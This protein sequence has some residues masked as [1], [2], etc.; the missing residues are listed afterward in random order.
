MTPEQLTAV[1]TNERRVYLSA[2]AGSG[3]TT[4]STARTERLLKED[5]DPESMLS[6]SF[7][8]KA[9][10]ELRE[11]LILALGNDEAARETVAK[12]T[13]GT[14][15]S[16]CYRILRAYGSRIGYV[17]ADR[18]TIVDAD[19][20]DLLL[21]RICQDFGYL[22]V[23]GNRSKWRSGLSLKRVKAWRDAAYT[24]MECEATAAHRPILDRILNRYWSELKAGYVLDFGKL[25][26]E[27]TRLF[28]E[29]PDVMELY[30]ARYKWIFVD[31]AQ[32]LSR[33]LH[34]FL[35]LLMADANVF[36]IAD[37]R[38][39]IYRFNGA[40]P[41][42]LADLVANHGFTA[43]SIPHTF[44]CPVSI[45]E[46]SNKL[47]WVNNEPNSPPAI[48][49]T[50]RQGT[51]ELIPGRTAA[52]IDAVRRLRTEH[53]YGWAEIAILARKHSTL[54]HIRFEMMN[55]RIPC[56]QS[57]G[58][59]EMSGRF[60]KL[61][62][63]LIRLAVNPADRFAF[64]RLANEYGLS[65]EE[66]GAIRAAAAS[67]GTA[68]MT[69]Y[70][71]GDYGSGIYSD[72]WNTEEPHWN[73]LT[74]KGWGTDCLADFNAM[75]FI[76]LAAE[77]LRI[78]YSVEGVAPAAWWRRH[79][80][81]GEFESL[82][83]ALE[84]AATFDQDKGDDWKVGDSVSLS[85]I[86][87]AKGLEYPAVILVEWNDG[88]FP[89]RRDMATEADLQ[90]SRRLAYVGMTRAKSYLGI[91]FRGPNDFGESREITPPSRFIAEAGL[92]T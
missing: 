42:L 37:Q 21:E 89:S 72:L 60:W 44:R 55:A 50:K 39:S 32:D 78:R 56:H 85:T 74:A 13:M 19:E 83:E 82:S 1:N 7:T 23:E 70:V 29:H 71:W 22:T 31:E 64:L 47:I 53:A 15:H 59:N 2:S 75:P 84:F 77:C 36:L 69:E 86:H 81:A 43:L 14:A 90:E 10:S 35:F 45:V 26:I 79:F 25:L 61:L 62:H 9:S 57:A 30:R 46:A 67:K 17:N 40:D 38:Q 27:T 12:L 8:R 49:F 34:S 63:A 68:E 73:D 92:S 88:E 24:G 76:D 87:A 33:A 51:I 66:Y 16:F 58:S 52:I 91:H 4:V 3:K 20:S 80:E 54:N 28:N 18:I 6:I 41:S 48:A 5:V 65:G 11:R